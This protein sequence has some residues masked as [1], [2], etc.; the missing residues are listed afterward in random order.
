MATKPKTGPK[1]ITFR[2]FETRMEAYAGFC[3]KCQAWTRANGCEPDACAYPCPRCK[4]ATVYGAE[5][6]M[7]QGLID[8][9]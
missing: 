7:L 2:T 4:G 9:G 5:E 8:V 3:V 1:R 6:C